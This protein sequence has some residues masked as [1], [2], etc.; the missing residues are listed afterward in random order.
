MPAA[1]IRREDAQ[2]LTH[3]L[4]DHLRTTAALAREF[5]DRFGG[6]DWAYL[7]GL[8]HD[9]G[10]YQAA[11][12]HRI[13]VLNDP[14]AHMESV[15]GKVP[16]AIAGAIHATESFSGNRLDAIRAE[17]V[18]TLI[19]AHHTGLQDW[20]GGTDRGLG[21]FQP[22]RDTLAAD[23]PTDLL[24]RSAPASAPIQSDPALW[25]RM[26]FS[27]LV[28]A[29]FLDTEAFMDP[30]RAGWRADWPELLELVPRFERHMAGFRS[31]SP[32]NHVRADVLSHCLTAAA[33]S[34][35]LFSLTVPT[36]GGKTLASLAFALEHARQHGKRRVIYVIPYTS[37]IEQTADVFRT[38]LGEEAILEHHSNLES[39]RETPRSRLASQNWDAPVVV[40]TNVQFFE[41]LFAARTS[42]VRKLHNIVDSVVVLDEAQLLPADFLKP[43]VG[44]LRELAQSYGATVLLCTATQPAL[45]SQTLPGIQFKGLDGVREIYPDTPSL[46]DK[47]ARVRVSVPEDLTQPVKW[48]AL[49][50]ELAQHHRVLCVVNRRDDARDLARMMPEDT[51]HLSAAM[52]GQHRSDR[53]RQI[54]TLLTSDGPVRVVSTQLVEAGVDLDFPVVY[55]ALAGL[56]SIA[57]AAGRCNREGRLPEPGRV[58]VFVPPSATPPGILRQGAEITARLLEQHRDDPLRPEH[59][60]RYFEELYWRRGDKLDRQDI[61]GRLAPGNAPHFPFANVADRFRLIDGSYLPVI[62][63]YGERAGALVD[64]LFDVGPDRTLLRKLQRYTVNLPQRLLPELQAKGVIIGDERSGLYVQA[65]DGA[66]DDRFGFVGHEGQGFSDGELIV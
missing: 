62:V 31:D 33:D 8:W 55:R 64:E 6:G 50:A 20:Y 16:H 57:Q 52:C 27:C 26:L 28:D 2:I 17:I 11:F 54:R 38:A 63:R 3:D 9:L 37:I 41:S 7:L 30:D 10:K 21:N 1:H 35:G 43:V 40:T 65:H 13:A 56:D 22:Y 45:E 15:A 49:A 23:P 5:A 24:G 66:Y 42:R 4:P 18:A 32:V 14:E 44:I 58:V 12:Q 53:I 61:C 39:E 29:D 25:M 60:R 51:I 59:F 47:L 36:G 46:Y 34:S 19:S 48:E